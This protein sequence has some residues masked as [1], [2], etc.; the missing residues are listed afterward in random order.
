MGPKPNFF[1][2]GLQCSIWR[3]SSFPLLKNIKQNFIQI[4]QRTWLSFSV[5]SFIKKQ[6]FQPFHPKC[7]FFRNYNVKGLSLIYLHSCYLKCL[8]QFHVIWIKLSMKISQYCLHPVNSLAMIYQQ[9]SDFLSWVLP[10]LDLF[11]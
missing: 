9:S 10:D 7:M 8:F 2:P 6:V 1:S 11:Q 3:I 5:C 4:T